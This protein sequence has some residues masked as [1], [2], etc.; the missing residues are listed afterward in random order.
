MSYLYKKLPFSVTVLAFTIASINSSYIQAADAEMSRDLTTNIAGWSKDNTSIDISNSGKIVELEWNSFDISGGETFEFIQ[1]DTSS[2]VMNNISDN[3]ASKILGTIKAN[4]HVFLVNNNGFTF[5]ENAVIDTQGFLATTFDADL[6][7]NKIKLTDGGSGIIKLQGLDILNNTQYAAFYSRKIDLTGTIQDS[8]DNSSIILSTQGHSSDTITLP[9]IGIDFDASAIS[10]SIEESLSINNDYNKIMSKEGSVYL[11]TNDINAL[12]N[13]NI[14]LPDQIKAKNLTAYVNNQTINQPHNTIITEL[15][16]FNSEIKNFTLVSNGNITVDNYI[17]GG[18]LNLV[19]KA[20]NITI[21][22]ASDSSNG[23]LGGITGLNNISLATNTPDGVIS[24]SDSIKVSDTLSLLG[25]VNI[26]NSQLTKNGIFDE[27]KLQAENSI[28]IHDIYSVDIINRSNPENENLS[29]LTETEFKIVAKDLTLGNLKTN[30]IDTTIS[31]DNIT[32]TGKNYNFNNAFTIKPD[33]FNINPSININSSINFFGDS[34]NLNNARF[35]LLNEN[36][37]AIFSNASNSDGLSNLSLENISMS[38]TSHGFNSLQLYLNNSA[39]SIDLSGD[40]TSKKLEVINQ[41]TNDFKINVSDNLFIKGLLEFDINN[42]KIN[43]TD[44]V[45]SIVGNGQPNSK[46]YINDIESKELNISGFE[47]L[48]IYGSKL[49]TQSG[50]LNIDT[51][52]TTL[53]GSDLLLKSDSGKIKISNNIDANEKKVIIE[54]GTGGFTLSGISNANDIIISNS[55]LTNINTEQ[56]L[57][58]NYLANSILDMSSLN[59]LDFIGD[60]HLSAE[61]M[62]LSETKIISSH[63]VTLSADS[64]TLSNINAA[65]LNINNGSVYSNELILTGD[66]ISKGS[67]NL[68]ANAIILRNDI[69][70]EGDINLLNKKEYTESGLIYSDT[71]K[72]VPTINGLKNLTINAKNKDAYLYDFGKTTPLASFTLNGEG[73]LHMMGRPHLSGTSGLSI[74]GNWDWDLLEP[75]SFITENQDLNLSGVNLNTVGSITFDTGSGSLSLG[76]IGSKGTV[77]DVIIN[78]AGTLNLHG[79]ITLVG[80]EFGYD[81]SKV[82]SI[83]LHKNTTLGSAEEP[84]IVNLG[85]VDIDGTYDL[86]IYSDD[87]S[88]GN[89]GSNIALQNLNINSGGDLILNNSINLVGN[90]NISANTIAINKDIT[91]TGLD[92]NLNATS[93]ITMSKLATLNSDYGNISLKSETGNIGLGALDAKGNV[94]IEASTGRIFNAIDDYKSNKLTSINITSDNLTLLGKAGIGESIASPIVIKIE[95]NGVINTESDGNIY[96]A[97]LSNAGINS[98]GRVIDTTSKTGTAI[99]D[100]YNLFQLSSINALIE[101]H[102]KTTLGLIENANWEADTDE[103]VKTIKTPNPSPNLYYSRKGWRLGY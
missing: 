32:L 7:D 82:S 101:P 6:I 54:S 93:D 5:G 50:N 53:K 95:N 98:Q 60:V 44:N 39:S 48:Q 73:T 71:S 85:D 56:S 51:G 91:S 103:S 33:N 92:I 97:N 13:S 37:D 34:I 55:S 99:I 75:Y 45:V 76:N 25:N 12:L 1:M 43:A 83:M 24:I 79:D 31:S 59:H 30:F 38:D 42:A 21:N 36:I 86:N 72:L 57:K 100:A 28:I 80:S 70:L 66:L 47:D 61:K 9:G 8:T 41:N 14:K 18:N 17:N 102:Y 77:T 65:S 81:F 26:T 64:L 4:G 89:I 11:N 23:F 88:L 68:D 16:N 96:I 22:E 84:S 49:I 94:F 62:N 29:N 67:L 3:S 19:F 90:A 10:G 20:K 2:V 78:E 58:G 69:T 52:K 40:I 15:L 63:S 46:A 74:L 87:I 27:I 35:N